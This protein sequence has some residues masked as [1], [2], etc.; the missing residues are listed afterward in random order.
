MRNAFLALGAVVALSLVAGPAA[1]A[2]TEADLLVAAR[3][4]DFINSVP[5]GDVR[6]GIVYDPNA[7]PSSQQAGEINALMAGGLRIGNLTLQPVMVPVGQLGADRSGIIFLAAGVGADGGKVGHAIRQRKIPCVTFD[8]GQVRNGNCVI[9]V[10]TQPKIQVFVNHAA[11]DA[12]GTV[13]EA[14]FRIMITEI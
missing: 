3:A 13:L 8:L 5:H 2:V 7:A 10:R 12:S 6:V 11:A 14:V 9:G 4:V 1:A